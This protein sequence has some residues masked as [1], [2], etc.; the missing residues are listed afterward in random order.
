MTRNAAYFTDSMRPFLYVVQLGPGGELPDPS[1]VRALPLSGGAA[2]AAGFNNGIETTP[3]ERGLLV[4]QSNAGKIFQVDPDTG[5]SVEVDLGGASVINGDGM[6]RR[7]ETL[8]VVQNRLNRVA[9]IR[10]DDEDDGA[11]VSGRVV[12]TITD[13]LLD[14]PSTAALFGPCLYAVDARFTTPPTPATTY[15]VIRL[16]A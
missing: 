16:R 9:V 7:G 11:A 1:A 4:V 13:P 12:R 5:A 10:L 8:Y 15:S 2:N 6:I 3:D 14:V